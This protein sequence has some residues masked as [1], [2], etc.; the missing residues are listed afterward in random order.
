MNPSSILGAATVWGISVNGFAH[1]SCKLV[2]RV[3]FPHAP[4][5]FCIVY[6]IMWEYK[7]IKEYFE[8][9][10]QMHLFSSCQNSDEIEKLAFKLLPKEQEVSLTGLLDFII[11]TDLHNHAELLNV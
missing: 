9:T 7:E 2:E 1:K 8:Q 11:L 4:L 10:N 6:N 3:Q 5:N